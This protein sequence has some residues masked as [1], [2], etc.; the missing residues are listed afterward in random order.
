MRWPSASTS[1]GIPSMST[2][3]PDNRWQERE[4]VRMTDVAYEGGQLHITFADGDTVSV[5]PA[6]LA[7][8]AAESIDWSA[9]R[10]D[11]PEIQA[12]TAGRMYAVSWLDV[13]A[14]TDEA[15]AAYLARVA[16]EE[17]R[18]VGRK[19]RHLRESRG[20]TSAALAARAQIT[21]Q[22]LSRIE[23]GRHDVVYSTLQRLL[24]AMNYTLRDLNEAPAETIAVDQ[25]VSRLKKTGLPKEVIRRLA[26]ANA[27]TSLVLDRL[28]RIFGW[29]TADL[30]GSETL[31]IRASV[32]EAAA[33]KATSAQQPALG[34]YVLYAH[35]LAALADHAMARSRILKL[36]ADAQDIRREILAEHDVV[37]FPVLLEWAWSRGVVV[38]PLFDPGQFHGACWLFDGRPVIVL[39]QVTEFDAR[40]AFDLAH[41]I[42]HVV[43]HLSS[44]VP[45][46]IEREEISL[47]TNDEAIEDEASEFAGALVL[48]DPERLAAAVVTRAS[49]KAERLQNAVRALAPKEHVSI[50]ALANYLAWRLEGEVDWWGAAANLQT[51]SQQPARLAVEA[52]LAHLDVDRLAADDRALLLDALGAS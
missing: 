43:L 32:A 41:E 42:G 23:L 1:Y 27:R 14:L 3:H 15:F 47:D 48:G 37:D 28:H 12:P 30:A 21:P 46:V 34:P 26:P 8:R 49:G 50:G 19:L 35:Y 39:K 33:F 7:P 51:R 52:L 22:S 2:T 17:S 11:G 45:A 4:Y 44:K 38:L 20:L 29:S 10:I 40:M 5:D 18:Q 25:V 16:D 9:A 36:P 24:A 13:R 31:P 6:R